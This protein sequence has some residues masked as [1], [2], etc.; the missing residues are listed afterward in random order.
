MNSYK[1]P[2]KTELRSLVGSAMNKYKEPGKTEL[3]SLVG[4]E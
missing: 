1:E 4:Y 3:R 2:G